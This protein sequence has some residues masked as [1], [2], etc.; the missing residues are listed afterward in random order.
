MGVARGEGIS[1]AWMVF[2]GCL[3]CFLKFWV[4]TWRKE[5]HTIAAG[6]SRDQ[7]TTPEPHKHVSSSPHPKP[8][9]F[10]IPATSQHPPSQLQRLT[11]RPPPAQTPHNAPHH[12]PSPPNSNNPSPLATL[13]LHN[14]NNRRT[15]G[16]NNRLLST[17]HGNPP[18]HPLRQHRIHHL[19]HLDLGRP[20]PRQARHGFLPSAAGAEGTA[21]GHLPAQY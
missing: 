18:P 17:D 14:R 13:P 9:S 5:R 11:P 7:N 6:I 16:H 1:R 19:H 3:R 10:S 20:R 15:N 8:N 21:V 2:W 4:L 12:T